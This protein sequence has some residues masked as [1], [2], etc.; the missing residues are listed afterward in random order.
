MSKAKDAFRTISEVSEALDTPAHVLRFWESKFTQVKPVKRAGGRRYYRP[1]DLALLGGIKILLHEQG[2]TIKGAQKLMREKGVK[3]VIALGNGMV[4][5]IINDTGHNAADVIEH[6]R[7]PAAESPREADIAAEAL[8]PQVAAEQ[9]AAPPAQPRLF[10]APSANA[11]VATPVPELAE[12]SHV[13][14]E[15]AEV[16]TAKPEEPE[17]A[18]EDAP[19]Q[20]DANPV[21][22]FLRRTAPDDT[23]VQ[24]AR[25]STGVT[26]APDPEPAPESDPEAETASDMPPPQAPAP[27]AA[28]LALPRLPDALPPVSSRL[29]ASLR[30]ADVDVI[31]ANAARIS[32]LLTRLA[33]VRDQMRRT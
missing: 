26:A 30:Q 4:G 12:P 3:H 16:E 32:P 22:S 21:P 33:E 31:S 9:D 24:S 28:A 10:T 17:L 23:S 27:I 11:P 19:S 18:S 20:A 2:M 8:A 25:A 15:A 29:M 13:D 6:V 1:D 7:A 14:T 5:D